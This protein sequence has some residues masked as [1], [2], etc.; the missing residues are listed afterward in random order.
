LDIPDHKILVYEL[1]LPILWGEMDSPG[2]CQQHGVLQATWS[3]PGC[4]GSTAINGGLSDGEEGP[5]IAN[6]FCNFYR[7]LVFP[8]DLLIKLYVANR[9]DARAS[10]PS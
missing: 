6:T 9:R 5:V 8:G 1:S 10:T 4:H 3:R 2:A 7:P